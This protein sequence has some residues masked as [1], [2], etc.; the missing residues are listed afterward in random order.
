MTD[1]VKSKWAHNENSMCH[2]RAIVA[3]HHIITANKKK[4]KLIWK[5]LKAI[6]ESS[7]SKEEAI[8]FL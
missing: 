2:A 7:R 8:T 1:I 6:R 3:T 5:Q 4:K